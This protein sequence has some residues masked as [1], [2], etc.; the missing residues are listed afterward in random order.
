MHDLEQVIGKG[1]ALELTFSS[2]HGQV[3]A[4]YWDATLKRLDWDDDDFSADEPTETVLAT[5]Q[6][7]RVSLDG[8]WYDSLDAES[9]DLEVVG[10]AFIDR[11]RV[12][13]VDEDSLFADS[14]VV[15]NFAEVIEEHRGSRVSHNLARGIG[16]I[17]RSDIIA[18]IPT[19][20]SL[21]ASGKLVEDPATFEGLRRHWEGA[22][23][24]RIPGTDVM[25]LPFDAR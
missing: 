8:A 9:A 12:T 11:D 2:Q 7:A 23:F 3:E 5:A 14:L 21:D 25:V 16:R 1:R 19:G 4:E 6:L 24:V 20:L 15:I 17:F 13:D 18:L 10:R 22:G